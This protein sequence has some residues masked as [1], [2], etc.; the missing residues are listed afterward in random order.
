MTYVCPI[1][2][3]KID[4]KQARLTALGVILVSVAIL[5]TQS[6]SLG[7]FLLI[8]F[9]LRFANLGKYSVL[10]LLSKLVSKQL[11]LHEKLVDRSPKRFA[12]LVGMLLSFAI[13][14]AIILDNILVSNILSLV[15]FIFASLESFLG[16]CAGCFLYTHLFYK[17]R[18]L[19]NI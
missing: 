14:L 8:D 4:E 13:L 11:N 3:V 1:D 15:L 6:T 7:I 18:I 5:F 16:F 12:A 17:I 9:V 2:G 10:A 19:R